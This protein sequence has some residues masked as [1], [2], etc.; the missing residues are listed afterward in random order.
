MDVGS[1]WLELFH[2]DPE[3]HLLTL[4]TLSCRESNFPRLGE[5]W[6]LNFLQVKVVND[7]KP[8]PRGKGEWAS[9]TTVL[10]TWTVNPSDWR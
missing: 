6:K 9:H 7:E 2:G 3:Q 4:T 5:F 1:V 10:H 8:C